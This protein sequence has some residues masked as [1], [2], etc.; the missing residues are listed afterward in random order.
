VSAEIIGLCSVPVIVALVLLRIPVAVAMGVVG[1]F[2]YALLDG[3][4]PAL[5]RLASTPFELSEG[6]SLSVV[7]L[8]LFMGAVATR[9]GMSQDLFRAANAILGGRRGA[10]AMAAV[11]ACAGFGAICGSSLATAATMSK[12]AIPEMRR[13]GYDERLAAGAVASGGTLGILIPPSVILIVYA[14]IAQASVAQ[15]FA[16]GLLP[17]I[18]LTLLHIVVIWVIV[19]WRPELAPAAA[20]GPVGWRPRLRDIVGMWHVF[21]LFAIA[22]GGIY[23]GFFSPTEAAA[24]GSV[25]AV[26]LGFATRRVRIPDIIDAMTE[27]VRTTAVLFF[28]VVMAFV[29]AYF[30]VLTHLPQSLVEYVSA[31]QWSPLAVILALILFYVVLGCFLDALG[32]ILVTVPVFLPLVTSLGY[33]PIW[34]GVLLVIVVE[35]GLITPPVGMNLFVIKAQQPSISIGTLYRGVLPFLSA[36]AT[37]IALLLLFPDLALWLPR[38]LFN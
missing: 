16:A 30:L 18:V 22:V 37:L 35:I 26:A 20:T 6:Y 36:G 4:T 1:V 29:Y 12:I 3:L 25:S 17:G 7:P 33:S 9:S 27:T 34:F 15:L 32:M 23:A 5:H 14:V 38:T 8:F 19:T 13:L 24:V 10:V 2:G 21:V 28:I 11:G 31:A